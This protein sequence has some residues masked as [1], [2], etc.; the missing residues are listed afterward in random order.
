MPTL[1][2]NARMNPALAERV[3]ASVTG[4]KTSPT[5]RISPSV[6]RRFVAWARVVLVVALAAAVYTG[7]TTYQRTRRALEAKRAEL[8][9]IVTIAQA[10]VTAKDRSAV[11][12]AA[13]W[14]NRLAGPYEGDVAAPPGLAA[15]LLRPAIYVRGAIDTMRTR[16]SLAGAAAASGKDALLFCLLDPPVARSEAAVIKKVR[17]V[18][19]GGA[20]FEERTANVRRLDEAMVGLPLLSSDFLGRVRAAEDVSELAK[21]KKHFEQVPLDRAKRAMRAELLIVALDEKGRTTDPTELDG[22][23]PHDVRVAIVELDSGRVMLR[24]RRHVDPS[25]IDKDQRPVYA[26]GADSCALGFDLRNEK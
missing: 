11:D 13:G 1:L 15:E 16:E 10:D 21:L 18:R 24:A 6:V 20:P 3:E 4:R 8:V 22:E 5:G 19:A 7:V 23:R 2:V 25:W 17:F 12:R 14:V 9:G 26:N